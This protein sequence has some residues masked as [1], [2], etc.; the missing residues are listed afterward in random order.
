MG[1]LFNLSDNKMFIYLF[2]LR[3]WWVANILFRFRG[4]EYRSIEVEEIFLESNSGDDT[5]R[6]IPQSDECRMYIGG[7]CER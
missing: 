6:V 7:Q 5:R 3:L 2:C 4:A 1:T